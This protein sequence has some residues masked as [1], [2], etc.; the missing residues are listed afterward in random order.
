[1]LFLGWREIP[2]DMVTDLKTS[3]FGPVD[4]ETT[5]Q[6]LFI[7]AHRPPADGG[8]IRA[9][10]ASLTDPKVLL[11]LYPPVYAEL[12]AT[13]GD[14][15]SIGI[16]QEDIYREVVTFSGNT[17]IE[18]KYPPVAVFGVSFETIGK[19]F[20]NDGNNISVSFIL[21]N[22]GLVRASK[23]CFGVVWV[24]YTTKYR[25]LEYNYEVTGISGG[26]SRVVGGTVMAFYNK[27]VATF[28]PDAPE[29]PEDDELTEQYRIIS[30]AIVQKE[31][32]YEY[33]PGWT[34][35]IGSPT[36]EDDL[37]DPKKP[38][39]VEERV[40]EIG[41]KDQY[42]RVLRRTFSVR[43]YTPKTFDELYEP[44]KETIWAPGEGPDE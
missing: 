18:L 24:S 44:V 33:P 1:M 30:K 42:D 16:R 3:V 14:V 23:V 17:E 22:G 6:R 40:H 21:T 25:L 11:R 39:V 5:D 38:W 26:G 32:A 34:G 43:I 7:E 41:Y 20:D 27:D 19:L 37:P 9:S 15:F 12:V 36:W 8:F 35:E 13:I 31:E 10:Y 28:T 4:R 2:L 29:L